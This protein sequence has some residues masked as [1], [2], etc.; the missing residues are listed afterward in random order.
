MIRAHV[1]HDGTRWSV[2]VLGETVHQSR[3]PVTAELFAIGYV[4]ER[5]GGEVVV[6]G[7]GH[8]PRRLR[9]EGRG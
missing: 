4:G 8:D 1:I 2:R 6:H 7:A 3:D 5:G 9:V